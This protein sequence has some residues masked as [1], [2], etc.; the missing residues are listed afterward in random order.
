MQRK[1]TQ[2][3]A[4]LPKRELPATR[5]QPQPIDPNML[6]LVAG[7]SPFRTWCAAPSST[8]LPFNSW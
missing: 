1:P 8:Q 4:A 2:I 7:G 3:A 5:T 6:R